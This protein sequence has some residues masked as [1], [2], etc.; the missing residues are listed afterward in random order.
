MIATLEGK[1]EYCGIDSAIVKVGGVGIRVYLPRSDLPKLGNIGDRVSLYTHLHVR[2]DNLSLY[3]FISSEEVAL[4]KNLISVS[5][6]GPKVAMS[7]LSGL[8]VEQLATAIVGGNIDLITQVP[9]VGKKLAS[10]LVVDLKSKLEQ[11]WKETA[12]PLAPEDSD[13]IAALTSLGYSLREATQAVS[14]IPD[15]P[16]L[17]L[18]E[19]VRAALQRLSGG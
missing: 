11:E 4:F 7:L 5:G 15:S 13:A 6:I 18:E 8:S 2:E 9:G 1:L 12:A 10:R 17:S 14:S 19:K 3:G 16:G